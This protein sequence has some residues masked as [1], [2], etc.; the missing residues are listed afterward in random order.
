MWL[1]LKEYRLLNTDELNL[2]L[3]SCETE[4]NILAGLK[5]VTNAI[6]ALVNGSHVDGILVNNAKQADEDHTIGHDMPQVVTL[7]V[8]GEALTYVLIVSEHIVEEPC[9][10]VSFF[11]LVRVLGTF[12]VAS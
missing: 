11:E 4:R 8:D 9:D 10:C 12:D 2:T 1:L 3:S 5:N 6:L 7:G